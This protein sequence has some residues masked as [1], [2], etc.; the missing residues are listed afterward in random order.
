MFPLKVH[1]YSFAIITNNNLVF[2]FSLIYVLLYIFNQFSF[3]FLFFVAVQW[4]KYILSYTLKLSLVV[5]CNSQRRRTNLF[6]GKLKK[7]LPT[8]F[9]NKLLFARLLFCFFFFENSFIVLW[10]IKL[11]WRLTST[12]F[13]FF[14]LLWLF[15]GK[16]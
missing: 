7:N 9:H 14:L 16:D 12:F 15:Y 10:E 5:H 3:L 2:L 6:Y 4:T 1:V 11:P 13:F 8:V